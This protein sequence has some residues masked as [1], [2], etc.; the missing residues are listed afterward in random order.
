[1]SVYVA[2]TSPQDARD[3]FEECMAEV[4]IGRRYPDGKLILGGEGGGCA[5]LF[6]FEDRP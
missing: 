6:T 4:S 3:L 5:Q 1:M 2:A